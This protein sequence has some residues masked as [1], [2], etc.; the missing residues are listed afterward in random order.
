MGTNWGCQP[1]PL[2]APLGVPVALSQQ[3]G[4]NLPRVIDV[5][6][7]SVAAW[8]SGAAVAASGLLRPTS[9][10]ETGF[11]YV[12]S[13]AG[14]TGP[15]EPAWPTTV[16]GTVTDGSITWTAAAPPATGQDTV[17]SAT[18]TQVSPPDATLMI[19]GQAT[20]ALTASAKVG[21]GTS[22]NPYTI[23]VAITM[24]SGVIYPVQLI[25]QVT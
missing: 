15:L 7:L 2:I 21:G 17:S 20:T 16:G 4:S 14:Q 12:A 25:L 1:P 5:S 18:W 22:G 3:A 10:H 24:A 11:V 19:T 23:N 13:A 8:Q 9:T 6:S